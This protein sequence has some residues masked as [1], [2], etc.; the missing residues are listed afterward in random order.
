MSRTLLRVALC[1]TFVAALGANALAG[2]VG[3]CIKAAAGNYKECKGN[4]K[5]DFQIA[6]D[7]CINK[8]HDCVEA[9]REQRSECIDATGFADLIKAC[10]TTMN[11]AIAN[12]KMIYPDDPVARDTCIDDAQVTGF[13]C[14]LDVRKSTK[15]ALNDCRKGNPDLGIQGF[16]P[17]VQDCP[18]GAGPVEDPKQCRADAAAAYVA[19]LHGCTGDFQFAKD[20]CRNKDHDC[21][22]ACRAGRDACEAPIQAALDQAVAGCKSELQDAKALCNGDPTCIT[23][24]LVVAFQCRDAAREAAK[25]GLTDC[26]L[27]NPAKGIQGFKPCVIACPPATP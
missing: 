20:S 24:A 17:C 15:D 6:Q 23:Q 13:L 19:C 5:E 9:C 2:E 27:G 12:C 8:D 16:R 4:C 21:V 18:V 22:D 26:R 3:Q 25:P 11:A 10:N 1:A 14:R 7:A